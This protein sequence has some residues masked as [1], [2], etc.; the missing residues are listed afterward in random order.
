M[1]LP[2]GSSEQRLCLIEHTPQGFTETMLEPVK[3]VPI[4]HGTS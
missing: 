2:L 3:F 4:V 1:V